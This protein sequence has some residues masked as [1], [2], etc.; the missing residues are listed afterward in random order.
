MEHGQQ[1]RE[2][3]VRRMSDD[4]ERKVG[5]NHWGN[6]RQG[7]ATAL[8]VLRSGMVRLVVETCLKTHKEI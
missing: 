5:S 4:A 1:E 7:T 6:P 2:T 3:K 8:Y